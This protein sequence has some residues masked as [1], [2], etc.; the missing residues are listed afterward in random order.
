MP[1]P[2]MVQKYLPPFTTKKIQLSIWQAVRAPYRPSM[3]AWSLAWIV[4]NW[5]SAMRCR[6]SPVCSWVSQANIQTLK[7]GVTVG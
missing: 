1:S 5:P 6:A 4:L 3:A 7:L 2:P